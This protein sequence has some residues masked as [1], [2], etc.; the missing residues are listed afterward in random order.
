MCPSSPLNLSAPQTPKRGI[1]MPPL[2]SPGEEVPKP[3]PV[4]EL[5]PK[6]NEI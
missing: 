4:Y 3:Q 5:F 2:E 6:Q 1:A